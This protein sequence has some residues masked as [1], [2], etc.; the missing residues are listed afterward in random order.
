MIMQGRP[1]V[2]C[3][4]SCDCVAAPAPARHVRCRCERTSRAFI[5]S[6]MS[7]DGNFRFVL[8]AAGVVRQRKMSRMGQELP[9]SE[10]TSS[11]LPVR[12]SPSD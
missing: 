4:W 1:R 9:C 6:A 10:I 3:L 8:I 5:N 7:S 12:V 2:A 11:K